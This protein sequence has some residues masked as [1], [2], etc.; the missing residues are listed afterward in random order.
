MRQDTDG[1]KQSKA[2]NSHIKKSWIH[3]VLS[4]RFVSGDMWGLASKN[5]FSFLEN[6]DE[7]AHFIALSGG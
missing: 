6:R 7:N 2:Y 5:P 4:M 1:K 3:I